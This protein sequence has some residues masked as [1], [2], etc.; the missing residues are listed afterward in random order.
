MFDSAPIIPT[1]TEGWRD[2]VSYGDIVSFRFPLAEEGAAGC[3]KARPCLVL[4]VEVRGGQRYALLAYGTTSRRRSNVGYEV[5]VRRRTDYLSAGLNE[6]TRFVGARRLL[7]PLT[8]VPSPSAGPRAP[9]ARP[10]R[11]RPAAG[12]ERGARPYSC[13]GRH[14]G[15]SAVP[16]ASRAPARPRLRGGAAH[17]ATG[18]ADGKGG[19]AMSA[20]L[21]RTLFERQV[22]LI[23]ALVQLMQGIDAHLMTRVTPHLPERARYAVTHL[24]ETLDEEDEIDPN[25]HFYVD[26]VLGEMRSAIAA[27]TTEEQVP[28][29]RER[30]IGC[31]EAF[32]TRRV[33]SPAAEALLAA[34]PP[35]EALY[36][37]ARD[38]LDFAKAIR[39]SLQLLDPK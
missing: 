18:R 11:R 4:D 15:R 34:L 32:D 30:L 38:A 37:A 24:V 17:A 13:R 16:P 20:A 1:M 28:I 35:L 5:H 31:T 23:Q 6:P 27:G 25:L 2:H 22:D 21:P 39:L 33:R 14:R 12:H 7:V 8:T 29:P 26:A 10:A 3:P 36:H 9:R 19:A